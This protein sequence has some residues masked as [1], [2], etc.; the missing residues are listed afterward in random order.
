ML[1][2]LFRDVLLYKASGQEERLIFKEQSFIVRQIADRGSFPGL[3][4]ILEEIGTA[5]RRI[6]ANVNYELTLEL[7]LLNIKENIA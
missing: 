6:R 7:L 2:L 4:R 5:G 3:N 1:L